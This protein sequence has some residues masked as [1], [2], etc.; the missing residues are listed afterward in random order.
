[1]AP[2]DIHISTHPKSM[3]PEHLQA[4]IRPNQSPYHHPKKSAQFS[5]PQKNQ[6]FKNPNFLQQSTITIK[7]R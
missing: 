6:K 1:M 7:G 5:E 4:K 2:F 3:Q